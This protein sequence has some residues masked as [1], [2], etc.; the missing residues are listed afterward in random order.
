MKAILQRVKS[1]SCVVEGS[2]TGKIN[3]GLMILLGVGQEDSKADA[4]LL[5]SKTA[6]LRIFEDE[7]GKMNRSVLD[8]GGS[9]LV[10]SNFTLYADCKKGRRPSFF[11]AASPDKANE[12]YEYF[13]SELE[14]N[15]V[16]CVQKG[17]FGADMQL[18]PVCNGPVTIILDT[19]ELR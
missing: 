7:N 4:E 3:D 18:D 8:I 2:T 6:F 9:A 1:A 17:I 15:G 10:I 5:A 12:L 13:C 14:K 11:E 19:D 16:S